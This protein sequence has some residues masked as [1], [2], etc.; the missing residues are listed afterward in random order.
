MPAQKV[1]KPWGFEIIFTEPDLPYAA[2]VLF[3]QAGKR[4]SLQYHDQKTE[5]HVLISGQVELTTGATKADLNTVPM[6]SNHGYTV[7]PNTVHRLTAKTDSV[8]FETSTPQVGTTYRLEDDYSRNNE[9]MD[10]NYN[11]KN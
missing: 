2:K 9:N 10:Q 7:R 6:V 8:I 1:K 3:I 11:L 4:L 5:T